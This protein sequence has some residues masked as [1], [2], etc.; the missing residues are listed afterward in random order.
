ML[1]NYGETITSI[2][3]RREEENR[4]ENPTNDIKITNL[5]NE[6]ACVNLGFEE[7]SKSSDMADDAPKRSK[8]DL[9]LNGF[10]GTTTSR[11]LNPVSILSKSSSFTPNSRVRLPKHKDQ[12]RTKP[13]T[14][15]ERRAIFSPRSYSP[16]NQS[17]KVNDNKMSPSNQS[18]SYDVYNAHRRLNREDSNAKRARVRFDLKDRTPGADDIEWERQVSNPDQMP[19]ILNSA[20]VYENVQPRRGKRN[21]KTDVLSPESSVTDGEQCEV[22][23]LE[24]DTGYMPIYEENTNN[25]DVNPR[26]PARTKHIDYEMQ[27]TSL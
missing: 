11:S 9:D 20:Y 7:T 23:D 17:S 6:Y 5:E 24:D 8:D 12:R 14:A 2:L 13:L 19:D 21:S 1:D 22:W 18:M 10:H 3:Q 4:Q 27:D 26:D 16:R 15:E 25:Y